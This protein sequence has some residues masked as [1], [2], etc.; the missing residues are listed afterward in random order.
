MTWTG[1][2][3]ASQSI[4]AAARTGVSVLKVLPMLP[5][6]PLNL[7]TPAPIVEKLEYETSDGKA[8]GDVYRPSSRGRHPAIVVFGYHLHPR[9][10]GVVI[11]RPFDRG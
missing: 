10:D 9:C 5:S 7:L 11:H 1:I 6:R 4:R 8:L 3:N 2:S